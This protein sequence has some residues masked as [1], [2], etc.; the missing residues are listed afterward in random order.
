MD[1]LADSIATPKPNPALFEHF[2]CFHVQFT[3]KQH[4]IDPLTNN[5]LQS[6]GTSFF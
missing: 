4:Q 2:A 3:P 6:T 1:D 5:P